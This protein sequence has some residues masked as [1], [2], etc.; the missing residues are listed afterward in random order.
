MANEK[1]EHIRKQID[2]LVEENQGRIGEFKYYDKKD[3]NGKL[4]T[5]ILA[6]LT[7]KV[8]K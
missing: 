8:E 6:V 4:C 2:C 5:M 7:F 3:E 1:R